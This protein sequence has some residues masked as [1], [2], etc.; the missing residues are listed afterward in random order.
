MS[1][2]PEKHLPSYQDM[3]PRARRRHQKRMYMRRKRATISGA[4]ADDTIK[5]LQPG[6]RRIS[7][8]NR[9]KSANMN[10]AGDRSTESVDFVMPKSQDPEDGASC[11][12][13]LENTE[14]EG[15]PRSAPAS[16]LPFQKALSDLCTCHVNGESIAA[17]G[18]DIFN[19][20]RIGKLLRCAAF[21]RKF[22]ISHVSHRL[23]I[24][25][26]EPQLASEDVSIKT[27]L[28][29]LIFETLRDFLVQ[30][31][32]RVIILEEAHRRFRGKI[33]A[34]RKNLDEVS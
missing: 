8:Q 22:R 9:S 29:F 23:F 13:E 4:E 14:N 27:D 18:L 17:A 19:Y 31:I 28:L 30:V 25:G 1:T 15:S 5:K 20:R 26:Y 7:T 3:S 24:S 21:Q 33:K 11:I 6:V 32:A 34:W 16:S 10:I 2:T 12:S